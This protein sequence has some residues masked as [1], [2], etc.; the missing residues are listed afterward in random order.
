MVTDWAQEWKGGM[1]HI[2]HHSEKPGH[3]GGWCWHWSIFRVTL[4]FY[5]LVSSTS[6]LISVQIL[7]WALE[8]ECVNRSFLRSF[9]IL[10]CN[11][12]ATWFSKVLRWRQILLIFWV[13]CVHITVLTEKGPHYDEF[14]NIACVWH[15]YHC[16]FSATTIILET[17]ISWVDS[18]SFHGWLILFSSANGHSPSFVS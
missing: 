16:N 17:F 9:T 12:S 2:G 11:T 1:D 7:S 15:E 14:I 8:W 3:L 10:F 4:L 6:T 5:S 13:L 18:F